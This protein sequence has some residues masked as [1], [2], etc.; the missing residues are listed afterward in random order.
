MAGIEHVDERIVGGFEVDLARE[1]EE[2]E[3]A[4]DAVG[5]RRGAPGG[6]N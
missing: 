3:E 1:G 2:R 4:E 6:G 5:R